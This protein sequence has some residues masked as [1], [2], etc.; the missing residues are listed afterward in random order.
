MSTD[1]IAIGLE[2]LA[3]KLDDMSKDVSDIRVKQ[4]ELIESVKHL[5]EDKER[6][7]GSVKEIRDIP[8]NTLVSFTKGI[9]TSLGAATAGWFIAR[10]GH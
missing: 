10:G 7:E 8:K 9:V 6:L 4:A 5:K 3:N 2:R 1:L